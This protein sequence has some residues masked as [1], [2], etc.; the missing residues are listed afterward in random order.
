M[1]S[2][3]GEGAG[4]AGRDGVAGGI[5]AAIARSHLGGIPPAA[6]RSL[7]DHAIVR[8]VAAGD[9]LHREGDHLMHLELVVSG[10]VRV[11]V[12]APDGRTLTVR[13]CRSGSLLGAISMF[14]AD[15]TMPASVRAVTP[16]RI[17]ALPAGEVATQVRRD[18][19]TAGAMLGELAERAMAFLG[20]I[21][22]TAFATVRQRVAR[23]LLDLASAAEP[24]ED[25]RARV[26]QQELADSIG[27]VREVVV[28]SLRDLRRDGLVETG[29]DGIELVDPERL[30]V[31]AYP[32]GSAA[33]SGAWNTGS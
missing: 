19:I 16:S 27:S 23:H 32:T 17:L 28:R 26:S 15:F 14:A 13:Y 29:H 4:P 21:P 25:L 1:T 10:L 6:L 7:L 33:P 11:F 24:G 22:G 20:E 8:D 9:D 30:A 31:E 18:P 5:D 12:R 3:G 2:I